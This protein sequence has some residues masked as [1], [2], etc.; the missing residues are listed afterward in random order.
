MFSHLDEWQG[1]VNVAHNMSPQVR[2]NVVAYCSKCSWRLAD[3]VECVCFKGL[4]YWHSTVYI[5]TCIQTYTALCQHLLYCWY[6]VPNIITDN[7]I[8]K[9]RSVLLITGTE[10]HHSLKYRE[11]QFFTAHTLCWMI[12]H[13]TVSRSMD[14]YYS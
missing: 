9:H 10:C 1:E 12:S 14:V 5:P 8:M 11:T 13:L 4:M 7:C 3:I 6:L 2:T